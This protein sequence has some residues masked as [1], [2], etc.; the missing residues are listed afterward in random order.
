MTP[1]TKIT[2]KSEL[3]ELFN[4][5]LIVIQP[6]KSILD[7]PN[8]VISSKDEFYFTRTKLVNVTNLGLVFEINYLETYGDIKTT[9]KNRSIF[10]KHIR[11][12]DK[13]LNKLRTIS[14]DELDLEN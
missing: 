14:I 4:S 5:N 1:V 9:I 11:I 8:V 12:L 10:C 3:I 6:V 13:Q 7:D 2:K